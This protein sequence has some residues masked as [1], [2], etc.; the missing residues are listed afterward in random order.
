MNSDNQRAAT[1]CAAHRSKYIRSICTVCDLC[2]LDYWDTKM[3]LNMALC[4]G[5]TPSNV[6]DLSFLHLHFA[7]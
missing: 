3:E 4:P 1:G 5:R 7:L 2:S 6:V